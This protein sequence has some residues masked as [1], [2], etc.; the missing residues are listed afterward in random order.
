MRGKS[1]MRVT[2][3]QEASDMVP[4]NIEGWDGCEGASSRD[5]L[6]ALASRG[7]DPEEW[8]RDSVL[9]AYDHYQADP[10]SVLTTAEV[11]ARLL[12]S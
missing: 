3:L 10:S 8:L 2:P 9:P 5:G 4:T 7:R 6:R 11:R 1:S 12:E